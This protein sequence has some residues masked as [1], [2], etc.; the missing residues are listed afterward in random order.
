M[1]QDAKQQ[2]ADYEEDRDEDYEEDDETPVTASSEGSS[3]T[4]KIVKLNLFKC[5][6]EEQKDF[7]ISLYGDRIFHIVYDILSAY[8]RCSVLYRLGH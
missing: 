6:Q 2:E 8:V 4:E 1:L 5:L 3:L 7:V